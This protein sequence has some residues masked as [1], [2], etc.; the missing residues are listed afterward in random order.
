MPLSSFEAKVISHCVHSYH[1]V[2]ISILNLND[3]CLKSLLTQKMLRISRSETCF[4][5]TSV[6][7]ELYFFFASWNKPLLR[8]KWNSGLSKG[9]SSSSSYWPL[10]SSIVSLRAFSLVIV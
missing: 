7:V 9:L 3:A 5:G 10:I 8:R 2:I 4:L 1:D 6:F